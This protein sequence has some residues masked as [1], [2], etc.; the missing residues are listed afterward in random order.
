MLPSVCISATHTP[1]STPAVDVISYML[2]G[3]QLLLGDY[4]T[5]VTH[6]VMH[7]LGVHSIQ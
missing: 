3:E 6:C 5:D 4:N 2:N 7:A 1:T